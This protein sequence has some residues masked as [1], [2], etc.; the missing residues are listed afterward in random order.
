MHQ[1][2]REVLA[3]TEAD[4]AAEV[5][6]P[7]V[8][9]D[10]GADGAAGVTNREPR[11]DTGLDGAV[12]RTKRRMQ[13]LARPRMCPLLQSRNRDASYAN[14]YATRCDHGSWAKRMGTTNLSVENVM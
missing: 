4:G 7:T 11:A 14:S 9:A 8:R 10:T 1:G 6:S 13:Q 5:E 2:S 12:R 3:L